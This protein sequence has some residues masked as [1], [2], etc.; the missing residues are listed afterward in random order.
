MSRQVPY[1][2]RDVYVEDYAFC[3]V[4]FSGVLIYYMEVE[5]MKSVILCVAMASLLLLGTIGKAVETE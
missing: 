2:E 5:S 3:V 1:P 4:R